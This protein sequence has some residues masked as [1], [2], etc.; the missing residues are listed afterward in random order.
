MLP[1]M[2]RVKESEGLRLPGVAGV[3]IDGVTDDKTVLAAEKGAH[4]ERNPRTARAQPARNSA[5]D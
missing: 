4:L 1:A 3:E 2:R 5:P